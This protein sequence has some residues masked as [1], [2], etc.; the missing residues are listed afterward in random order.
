MANLGTVA[1]LLEASL[2]PRQSKQGETI[3][4]LVVI[5]VLTQLFSLGIK[6]TDIC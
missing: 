6:S 1:Q 3:N 5:F 2:D 4:L